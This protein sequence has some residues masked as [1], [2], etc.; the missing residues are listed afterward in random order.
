LPGAPPVR[1]AARCFDGLVATGF[2]GVAA[3]FFADAF[4]F[5]GAGG[6]GGAAS[7]DADA[8]AGLS[9]PVRVRRIEAT[10]LSPVLSFVVML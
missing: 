3:R 4:A 7:A 9:V 10:S 2:A 1:F 6:G 8:S 5:G